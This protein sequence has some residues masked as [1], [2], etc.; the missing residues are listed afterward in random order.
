M[1]VLLNLLMDQILYKIITFSLTL[2][3]CLGESE[4]DSYFGG[5]A[6]NAEKD[7]IE[8]PGF[9]LDCEQDLSN[10]KSLGC[11]CEED[12][13]CSS[14]K[15]LSTPRK[16]RYC[17]QNAGT[18]FPRY[19]LTDQYGESVDLYDFGGH[20][21]LIVIELSTSWCSPCRQLASFLTYGDEEVFKN[22]WWKPEYRIIKELVH[23]DKIYFINI[24]IQDVYR[25]PASLYSA[26]DWFQ[27]F[28]D[29]K[30]PILVDSDYRVRDWMR[31]TGYPTVIILNDKM[32]V[33][34]FSLRGCHDAFNLLSSMNW[35]EEN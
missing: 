7:K 12:D 30:V 25:E 9:L 4:S 23:N 5:W 8:D 16:G 18:I 17:G 28:P 13:E 11:L 26:E 10:K 31:A 35:G 14:G 29:E 33:V 19:K 24:Q 1:V 3:L 15:C 22:R 2:S 27:E 34:Q 32:E 6:I 20:G 21:K